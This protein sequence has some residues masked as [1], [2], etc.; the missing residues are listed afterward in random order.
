MA[1]NYEAFSVMKYNTAG[2]L[3]AQASVSVKVRLDGAGSDAAESPL[4][5]NADGVIVAGSIAAGSPG[6]IV[7][8][9]IENS[10]GTAQS[11]SQTL[12]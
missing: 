5:T 1:G 11:T 7:H 2:V 9:R 8:F 12:T 10:S 3:E 6:G 4:T